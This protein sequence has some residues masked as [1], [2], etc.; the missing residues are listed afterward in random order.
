MD[1]T[2]ISYVYN[3]NSEALPPMLI[4][5]NCQHCFISFSQRPPKPS[6]IYPK[7]YLCIINNFTLTK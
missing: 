6:E 3:F 5:L 2:N 4:I 1:F 7:C